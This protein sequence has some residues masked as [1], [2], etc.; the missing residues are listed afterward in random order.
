MEIFDKI[1]SIDFETEAISGAL[2][3]KPVG[4]AI[5][6]GNA[7]SFYLA[8]GHSDGN[9]CTFEKAK[10][11]LA[12]AYRGPC[13]FHNSMFDIAVSS[14]YMGLPYPAELHDTLLLLFL[15]DPHAKSLALKPA[16]EKLLNL[17]PEEQD[18][19]KE[20]I[21]L[22]VPGAKPSTA[23]AYIS[24]APVRFVAPYACGDVDRT[25]EL[26]KLL[27]PTQQGVAYDR[28]R[29]L[30]PILVQNT[31]EGVRLDTQKLTR[32]VP[33]YLKAQKEVA[34]R[35]YAKLGYT[36]NIGSSEE[37]A[38]AIENSDIEVEWVLTPTGKRSTAKKNLLVGVKDEE[39]LALL[40][41]HG[42]LST[43]L[44]SFFSNWVDKVSTTS[45]LHFSWNQV[46]NNEAGKDAIGT[47]T[48]R[49]SSTPSVLN[50]PKLPKEFD[51]KFRL[52]PLPA[53][54]SYFL[55]DEKHIWISSDY[56]AQEVRILAHYEDDV[57][58][59]SYREKPRLDMHQK[60]A[61]VVS[62][63]TGRPLS[64]RDAKTLVFSVLYG[65]GLAATAVAL[66]VTELE[67][68]SVRKAFYDTIPGIKKVQAS[69]KYNTDRDLPIKTLGQRKYFKEQSREIKDKRTG[70]MRY[71]DFG[72]KM[73]NYLIQGSAA[74]MTK[75]AIINYNEIK[76]DGRLLLSVHDQIC[77]S[78]PPREAK[79][80]EAAM[81]DIK[82][83]VPIEV[84][85]SAGPNF[86]DLKELE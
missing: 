33:N 38:E 83:D 68:Q 57:L 22:K 11:Y 4:V 18:L 41:Y 85:I 25:Y 26:F 54:R 19:L 81:K 29:K 32:D 84:D 70:N 50:I 36:F 59:N 45:M 80:L 66:G 8:W 27:Y 63:N 44:E 28:E 71:A 53:M 77:I 58:M 46:R 72:Y 10:E 52:P 34:D 61:D 67:C 55:P 30:V 31:L 76:K 69:I 35:I 24:M 82:L 3:P 65:Q 62:E 40:G 51:A 5:K 9:N 6:Y 64:R 17:Q 20:W 15:Y 56:Q 37:L 12:E 49:L 23:G 21:L 73:L 74:D 75:Q 47:R 48:G 1:T 16:A 14:Y 43:Y 86:H 42:T 39:L 60:I 79:L 13:L 78:A 7:P 2:P